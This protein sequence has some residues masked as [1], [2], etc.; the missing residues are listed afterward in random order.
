[1][2]G[3]IM[4]R[5]L[6]SACAAMLIAGCATPQ[7]L[8]AYDEEIKGLGRAGE[9][10]GSDDENREFN[11]LVNAIGKDSAL[12]SRK[13]REF[14]I[15]EG[16]LG[17]AVLAAAAYGAFNTSFDGGNL[18]DAAFAAA[19]LGALGSWLKPGD[20]RDAYAKASDQL[21]CLYEHGNVFAIG[22]TARSS[23]VVDAAAIARAM[24]GPRAKADV[25]A[26]LVGG[27]D[28]N[29][30]IGALAQESFGEEAVIPKT[31]MVSAAD[32]RL[33]IE[34][35]R[36]KTQAVTA[37][38]NIF[39]AQESENEIFKKRFAIV[40]AK[41]LE[42]IGAL[43]KSN[44]FSGADY[45]ASRKAIADAAAAAAQANANAQQ[46]I[47]TMSM[48]FTTSADSFSGFEADLTRFADAQ[49]AI[50]LCNAAAN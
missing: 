34:S 11:A 27:A 48:L 36:M 49:E 30:L 5:L 21:K 25:G 2:W 44:R 28:I 37:I 46:G 40:S 43:Y 14:N 19:S 26:L 38:A 10:V 8:N 20:R 24:S 45:E 31:G 15:I 39:S 23:R 32:A 9:S 13:S 22:E 47:T 17:L 50:A 42:I 7:S 12:L 18:K 33:A 4:N 1:M 6:A 35:A 29:Q 3:H 41:Y 16:G